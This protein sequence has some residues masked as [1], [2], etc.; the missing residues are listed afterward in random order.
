DGRT[1][2]HLAA[3]EGHSEVVAALLERG[4]DA[5]AQDR[6]GGSPLDDALRNGDASGIADVLRALGGVPQKGHAAKDE[7]SRHLKEPGDR[8]AHLNA[9]QD[10]MLIDWADVR[11]GDKIGGGSFGVVYKATWNRTPVACKSL[12]RASTNE[13][14][15]LA[16]AD[17]MIEASILRQLRH[18]NICMLLGYCTVEGHELMVTELMRCSLLDIL[19]AAKAHEGHA[20]L[21]KAR[22]L[23]YM[24][25]LARGMNYLHTCS[26]P[27]LH[28]DLK[29][30][31]LLL[32]ASNTLRISD[33]GLA[34]IRRNT[35]SN[36]LLDLTG[37]TGSFR[38]MA[39]EVYKHQPYGRPVDVYS[40]AMIAFNLLA[41]HAPWAELAGDRAARLA[42]RGERP[43]M[44]RN[45]DEKIQ[46]LLK[47]AWAHESVM[48]PSFAALL[49]MLEQ[50]E[51]QIERA[52]D[53]VIPG[54]RGGCECAL[55]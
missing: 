20:T 3:G 24:R 22:A 55:S 39:P 4:A 13:Q 50:V 31:N 12:L 17:F 25:E 16:L 18:P 14:R 21:T 9:I 37:E 40:F 42:S 38:F 48:R 11:V 28:R 47:C 7:D 44:P 53:A 27:I 29:P 35:S 23:R 1:A 30:A 15:A 10:S 43:I 8:V 41:V 46:Q 45:W 34:T 52:P 51:D 5:V 2:L 6:W 49:D 33:F 32:D 36:P 19:K 26:P 54:N